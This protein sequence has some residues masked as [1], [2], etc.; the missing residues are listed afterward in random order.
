MRPDWDTYFLQIA[1]SVATRSTCD[2]LHVGAVLTK[3][4]KII[5]SGYN[6]SI[7]GEPH[8]DDI[9]HDLV[10]GH[11]CRTIHAEVNAIAQAASLGIATEGT[12]LYCTH[13]PC[14]ECA[15]IIVAAGIKH[16]FYSEA[17][18]PNPRTLSLTTTS[19]VNR[20]IS[21]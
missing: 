21:V 7:P 16:V 12:T 20:K 6:G 10:E 14:W 8:C 15:K 19:M 3:D 2:R 1:Y 18:R 5:A 11:C 4:R 17:Y 9:G 13:L